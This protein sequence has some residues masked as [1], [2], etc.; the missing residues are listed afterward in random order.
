[1][2]GQGKATLSYQGTS[3]T[4][5]SP[6]VPHGNTDDVLRIN[7]TFHVGWDERSHLI[8]DPLRPLRLIRYVELSASQRVEVTGIQLLGTLLHD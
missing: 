5:V 8:I 2:S 4:T 6:N 7:L 1:M 3:F